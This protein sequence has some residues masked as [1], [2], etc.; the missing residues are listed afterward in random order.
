MHAM[1]K[2]GSVALL[3][4]VA[5]QANLEY[6][7]H[8]ISI[9]MVAVVA[10]AAA[11]AYIACLKSYSLLKS[12]TVSLAFGGIVW[13]FIPVVMDCV[14]ADILRP[15]VKFPYTAEQYPDLKGKEYLH[16]RE[17]R[18]VSMQEAGELVKQSTLPLLFKGI[19]KDSTDKG[20]VIINR[21]ME[22]D[23]KFRG[24]SYDYKPYD[25]FRGS[26][27]KIN[28]EDNK[29]TVKEVLDPS[30][31]MYLS[32]EPFLVRDEMVEMVGEEIYSKTLA[33]TNFIGNFNQSVVTAYPHAAPS[34]VSWAL[35]M[36]GDK[37][38]FLW[39][40]EVFAANMN[41]QWFSRTSFPGRGS[42][43]YLFSLP[44]YKVRVEAG[45]ILSFPPLWQHTVITH[46]GPNLLLNLR[47][48]YGPQWVPS[49]VGFMRLLISKGVSYVL[50][51]GVA[52]SHF[53]DALRKV[54]VDDI[55]EAFD[56]N[57][58]MLKW[59]DVENYL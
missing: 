14:H 56:T 36:V 30:T 33:D 48:M 34:G 20:M 15:F 16:I 13:I 26:K 59:D 17:V 8:L 57:P 10:L 38:W 1:L 35:Q 23:E 11:F 49:Y 18:D 32:F 6:Q 45:D 47:T 40:P 25:F 12:V 46:P 4:A 5:Y 37:T 55:N 51:K 54:R 31:T 39:S 28:G 7:V 27:L 41:N 52:A 24:Q 44:T 3:G 19:I 22:S 50:S 2:F 53:A 43:K 9:N 21:L 29:L 42:E 58:E